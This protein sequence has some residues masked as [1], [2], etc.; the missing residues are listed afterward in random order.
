MSRRNLFF[1]IAA[2]FSFAAAAAEYEVS[3]TITQT[4]TNFNAP[5]IQSR[6]DFTVFVRDCGWLIQTTETNSQGVVNRRETGCTNGAE[7]V[8]CLI[9][10]PNLLVPN[11]PGSV[12]S[13]NSAARFHT[14]MI[15]SNSIPVGFL[16]ISVVGHLWLMFASQC[17]WGK[18]TSDSLIPV[19]DWRASA[20]VNPDLRLTA[21][22]ELL[23]GKGS[24][25]R[26]VR[27][28]SGP[29]QTNGFYKATGTTAAGETLIPS[30]F[31]FEE[32]HVRGPGMEVVRKR[33]EAHVTSVKA[34]SSR[35]GLLPIPENRTIVMDYRLAQPGTT[36]IPTYTQ[37]ADQSWASVE[38]ARRLAA[39]NTQRRGTPRPSRVV[40]GVMCTLLVAP[41]L[42][43]LP[44]KRWRMRSQS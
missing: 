5:V 25:P 39:A 33:V 26:E 37:P 4:I 43:F 9:D 17:Y 16:D 24:L 40:I 44:W 35:V 22:W 8:D 31:V 19:Y 7:I 34:K 41:L 18:L 3:G 15:I 38:K 13:N 27:Y 42:F 30:G 36:H 6:A 21:E 11:S 23:A 29:D 20:G 28:L 10:L 2:L 32:R 1:I 14:A 12:G